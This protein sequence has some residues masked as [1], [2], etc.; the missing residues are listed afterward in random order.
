MGANSQEFLSMFP[1]YGQ[2]VGNNPQHNEMANNY[3]G[4]MANVIKSFNPSISDV[5]ARALAWGGLEMTTVWRNQDTTSIKN[6]N[7]KAKFPTTA[8]YTDYNLKKCD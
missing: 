4:K 2:Y 1:I 7:H 8:D 3:I 6:M 5:D